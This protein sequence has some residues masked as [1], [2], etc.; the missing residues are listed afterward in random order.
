MYILALHK[1]DTAVEQVAGCSG[2]VQLLLDLLKRI[3]EEPPCF[4]GNHATAFTSF[5]GKMVSMK[6]LSDEQMTQMVDPLLQS[7]S[8]RL[9]LDESFRVS[10]LGL[11]SKV[12][13][14]STCLSSSI[15]PLSSLCTLALDASYW[16]VQDSALSC[17]STML[18][19]SSLSPICAKSIPPLKSSLATL[20]TASTSRYVRSSALRTLSCLVRHPASL[21]T[22]LAALGMLPFFSLEEGDYIGL[23]ISPDTF[24]EEYYEIYRRELIFLV[25]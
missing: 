9:S 11:L 3:P 16:P 13:A 8:L 10:L 18:S 17:I 5:M 24:F 15:S 4:K 14:S 7:A 19:N 6:F 12:F 23:N 20:L 25:A 2:A 22:S 21:L 1:V